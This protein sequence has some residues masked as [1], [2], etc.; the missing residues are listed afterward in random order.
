MEPRAFLRFLFYMKQ[1]KIPFVQEEKKLSGLLRAYRA[2]ELG[3][4][5][6]LLILL[7]RRVQAFPVRYGYS[8]ESME[9]SLFC[10]YV[11]EKVFSCIDRYRESETGHFG[12]WFYGVLCNAWKDVTLRMNRINLIGCDMD[13]FTDSRFHPIR[14]PQDFTEP[15]DH[16]PHTAK[17]VGRRQGL[18]LQGEL[19][20]GIMALLNENEQRLL[21]LRYPGLIAEGHVRSFAALFAEGKRQ[22][23]LLRLLE[24]TR[25]RANSDE[26]QILEKLSYLHVRYLRLYDLP[27]AKL[28]RAKLQR[29]ELRRHILRRR[30][31]LLAQLHSSLGKISFKTVSR[32][33]GL[34]FGTVTSIVH[35]ARC[36]IEQSLGGDAAGCVR[37]SPGR[38]Q[39]MPIRRETLN[40]RESPKRSA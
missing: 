1:Q 29:E 4:R 2:G 8:V 38:G 31:N 25:T 18:M 15:R 5:E 21:L 17:A 24:Y 37:L 3:A 6:Q 20:R 14:R 19:S 35:R 30:A 9:N 23:A 33:T 36:K 12:A 39:N 13:I 34:P 26:R 10:D 7:W 16:L 27:R 22:R 32:V 11:L 28:Q 40:S